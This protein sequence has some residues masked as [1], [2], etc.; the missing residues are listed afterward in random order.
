[1]RVHRIYCIYVFIQKWKLLNTIKRKYKKLLQYST[2]YFTFQWELLLWD[3]KFYLCTKNVFYF[4]GG[5]GCDTW[6]WWFWGFELLMLL[7]VNHEDVFFV[8]WSN[9]NLDRIA[10]S[11]TYQ[12]II[13]GVL[14]F[15]VKEKDLFDYPINKLW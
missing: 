6:G 14:W 2:F 7:F 9:K 4:E 8:E 12:K 3:Q 11:F 13:Q 5:C 10:F 1:M 15:I